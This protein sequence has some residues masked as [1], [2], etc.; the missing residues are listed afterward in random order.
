VISQIYLYFYNPLRTETATMYVFS[1]EVSFRGVFVR[2]ERLV[3]YNISGTD[4]ISYVHPDAS[5][6]ARNSVVA[7]SYKTREDILLRKRAEELAERVKLLEAAQALSNT[8]NSQLE[9]FTNQITATHLQLMQ[10]ISAGDYSSVARLKN[11]YLSLKCRRNMLRDETADYTAQIYLLNSQINDLRARMSAQ[12]GDIRIEEAGYFVSTAD[13]FE[14][15]LNSET[16]R[17]LRISD[18]ER[19]IREP[20]PG[21]ADNVIGKMIDDYKWWFIGVF[22]T[23]KTRQIFEG[24]AVEFRIGGSSRVVSATVT[25][26]RNQV[27][28][29]SIIIFECDVLTEEFASK[30]TSQFNLMLDTHRGIRIPTAAVHFNDEGEPG[31]YVRNGAELGFRKIKVMRTEQ[32]FYLV[33]D[34]TDERGYISLYDNVV[35]RGTDLY[36][37]KIVR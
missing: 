1:E 30:R 29:D 7:N 32:N 26:V 8:D 24:S 5:R 3:H 27:E 10:S 11:E 23:D 19:I 28:G 20:A 34:T 2:N 15:T 4:I 13:G 31:V 25:S 35:V 18:I 17:N 33:E 6:L 12:P 16:L 14:G 37:G 9:S 36:D 22:D 21:V